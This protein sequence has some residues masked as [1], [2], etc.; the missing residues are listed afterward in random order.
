MGTAVQLPVPCFETWA[1]IFASSSAV[2][3]PLFTPILSQHG[4]LTISEKKMV[5]K[6]G[7]E[8]EGRRWNMKIRNWFSFKSHTMPHMLRGSKELVLESGSI[9]VNYLVKCRL[10]PSKHNFIVLI[11]WINCL[12]V[13]RKRKSII[14]ISGNHKFDD[15]TYFKQEIQPM[16]AEIVCG[17]EFIW[18][19]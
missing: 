13:W 5:E 2:Q 8:G 1:S 12:I 10:K 16:M 17:L 19:C 6:F 14:L 18:N 3:R 4:G 15:G 11:V 9:W 7:R